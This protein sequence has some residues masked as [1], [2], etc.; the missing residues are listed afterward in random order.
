MNL[1]SSR[2]VEFLINWRSDKPNF[3]GRVLDLAVEMY[4]NDFWEWH[5]V[6]VTEA[7]L[8]DLVSIGY[9]M[10]LVQPISKPCK[11]F[12]GE[13]TILQPN[14]KPSS[15]LRAGKELQTIKFTGS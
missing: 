12:V 11:T 7:W 8:E 10:P 13:E 6:I 3:F 4:K 5:D 14:E 15:F 9:E 1:H 2:F